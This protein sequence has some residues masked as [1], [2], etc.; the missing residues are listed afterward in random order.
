MATTK[1]ATKEFERISLTIKPFTGAQSAD[2]VEVLKAQ[3]A[4]GLA[5]VKLRLVIHADSHT[6]QAYAKVE[7]W[8]GEWKLVHSIPGHAMK[9]RDGYDR[10][11]D[12]PSNFAADRAELLR[13]AAAVL[14]VVS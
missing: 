5:S 11:S 2:L 12:K 4:D 10:N 6:P 13:V 14:E 9:S 7:V 1:T 8:A 3:R